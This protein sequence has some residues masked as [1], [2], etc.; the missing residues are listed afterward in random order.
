MAATAAPVQEQGVSRVARPDQAGT[1]EVVLSAPGKAAT[2][3]IAV[4]T[5]TTAGSAQGP[6]S[7]SRSRRAGA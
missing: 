7:S 6:A 3:R 2:V 1:A 5:A 4:G